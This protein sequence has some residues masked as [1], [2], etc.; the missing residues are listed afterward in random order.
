MTFLNPAILF[1]LIATSIP[2]ILHF[3]NL[4]KLKKVEFST[5]LFLKQLQKSRIRKI[6][7]KQWLLLLLRILIIVF[8]VF[9][10]ARP[11]LKNA[12]FSKGA[13]KTTAVFLI[14]NTFSMSVVTNSGS[15]FNISKQ[16]AK[17]LLNN[18]NA[19]DEII[20]LP[21]VNNTG[22]EIKPSSNFDIVRKTIDELQLS[23]QTNT[24]NNVLTRA[25]QILYE[26]KNLNKEIYILTDLQK[27]R[28]YNSPAEI[29]N[30]SHLLK[31]VNIYLIDVHEK[32]IKNLGIEDFKV[33]NQI[34]E[35][36]KNISFSSVI[37][38]YS[39]TKA[40]NVVVSLFMNGKRSAQQSINLNP[41]ESQIVNFETTLIDTGL[42]TATVELEDDDIVYDNKCYT[43]L[44]VPSN[45]KILILTD[46]NDDAKFIKLALLNQNGNLFQITE[47]DL[48]TI[49]STK[50]E[51][52][53]AVFIIGSNKISDK[54]K[55]K[56]YIENGGAVTI[57][58]A[59]N[60]S[61]E[62]L[63][64]LYKY[65]NLS[66]PINFS[67]NLNSFDSFT[68]FNKVELEHPLFE[69]LFEDKSKVKVE[70]PEI[71]YYLKTQTGSTG[72]IIISLIDNS[73]FLSEYK[74]GNGRV[75]NFNISPTLSW[76][77]FP[78][79]S[80]FAPL[81]NKIVFYMSS[82]IKYE[83]NHHA[84]D[85]LVVNIQS[86]ESNLIKV[87]NPENI[88]EFINTDSLI[89][90]NYL[91]YNKTDLAGVYKFYSNQKLIDYFSVNHDAKESVAE[92]E[93]AN[94]FKEYLERIGFKG[95]FANVTPDK[96]YTRI[97]NQTR[98]GVELW[99]YFLIFAFII[100]ILE[101][102]IS[103]NSKK[104]MIEN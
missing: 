40:T 70:S 6:K 29:M 68:L 27:D 16:I 86:R 84:G 100:T 42:V 78:L 44:Y 90:K 59:S 50:I 33:N 62:S 88:E 8:L 51:D 1:G 32:E 17:N 55:L 91:S 19:K 41:Y 30:L 87:I 76:S 52:F 99:K 104:D 10:F 61:L 34:Y 94:K 31:N 54:E 92:Y 26:S 12:S 85:E 4:R 7:I 72:R 77:N 81:I 96:D 101:M 48:S 103:K 75:L 80:L 66:E 79:K 3:I 11:T 60:S 2:I 102:F 69:N 13:A 93:P 46:Y 35:K 97:I 25:S 63:K 21:F 53:D 43:A 71:Y 20:I 18:F 95:N 24:L 22:I 65:L 45:I 83:Q 98:F 64:S 28:I 39:N 15:Y 49:S 5:L 38:N 89:N 82:K 73:P 58:P 37:K 23:Y 47:K 74:I 36:N 67:G 14:D 9:A 56:K 57:M